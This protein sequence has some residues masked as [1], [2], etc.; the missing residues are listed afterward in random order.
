MFYTM[1]YVKCAIAARL[2]SVV[3]FMYVG[4]YLIFSTLCNIGVSFGG[5]GERGHLSPP[6][7]KFFP[8]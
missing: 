2:V 1:E 3:V 8:P 6:F 4:C 7:K 5:G